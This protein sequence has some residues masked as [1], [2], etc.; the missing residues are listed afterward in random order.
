[1]SDDLT[2]QVLAQNSDNV[3]KLFD[4]ITRVDERVKNIQD[5]QAELSGQIKEIVIDYHELLERI[6]TLEAK[7]GKLV[8]EE[9]IKYTDKV[10]D[11]DKRILGLEHSSRSNEGRW[12][13]VFSFLI[14]L[15]WVVLAAWVLFKLNLNPPPIP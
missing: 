5:N 6:I 13:R 8:Q 7:H 15:I 2:I 9:I 11:I 4:L 14:Q 10:A 1:M 12:N 3:Q